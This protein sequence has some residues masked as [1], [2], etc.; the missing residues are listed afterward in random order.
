MKFKQFLDEEAKPEDVIRLDVPL[1]IRM[2]EFARENAK[3][4]RELHEI[5]ERAIKLCASGKMLSMDD[6][7]DLVTAL[8]T[9]PDDP[10][11][12]P[13]KAYATL[14]TDPAFDSDE[15]TDLDI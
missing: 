15:N 6:Y 13:P 7:N 11:S 2:M 4:D 10:N 12:A 9:T 1:F 3:T 5:S 14:K 8:T